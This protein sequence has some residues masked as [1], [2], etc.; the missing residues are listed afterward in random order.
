MTPLRTIA[1]ATAVA[2]P[3]GVL[4]AQVVP[5]WGAGTGPKVECPAFMDDLMRSSNLLGYSGD[6][7]P[8]NELHEELVKR[9]VTLPSPPSLT[10]APRYSG[11]GGAEALL[12][13]YESAKKAYAAKWEDIKGSP[14]YHQ[15]REAILSRQR[16]ETL[17]ACLRLRAIQEGG[18][19]R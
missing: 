16:D 10:F 5:R 18:V 11:R 14:E 3:L 2:L 8:P 15:A 12:S 13:E 17:R 1:L 9:G 4:I 7:I 6:R 19:F